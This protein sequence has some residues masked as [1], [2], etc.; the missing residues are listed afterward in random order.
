MFLVLK[1]WH[2]GSNDH[3]LWNQLVDE[4]TTSND[5]CWNLIT[6]NFDAVNPLDQTAVG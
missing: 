5:H 2:I 1:S 3:S 6:Q 4:E